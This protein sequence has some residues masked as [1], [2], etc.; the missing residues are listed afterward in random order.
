MTGM[1]GPRRYWIKKQP[2]VEGN[3]QHQLLQVV[4]ALGSAG[5][6]LLRHSGT[7]CSSSYL[8]SSVS[9]ILGGSVHIHRYL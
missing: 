2:A 1:A 5:A 4:R 7:F 6:S 3:V 8:H 9:S